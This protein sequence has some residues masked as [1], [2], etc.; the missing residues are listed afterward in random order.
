MRIVIRRGKSPQKLQVEVHC[1][2]PK[3]PKTAVLSSQNNHFD[4]MH[5]SNHAFCACRMRLMRFAPRTT[6]RDRV[7]KGRE[8]VNASPELLGI[9]VLL[10]V[11]T[12][13]GLKAS[14]DSTF[15]TYA[16]KY[17]S[18]LEHPFV[19]MKEFKLFWKIFTLQQN[20]GS[21]WGDLE[22]DRGSTII[23]DEHPELHTCNSGTAPKSSKSGKNNNK[24]KQ[25]Y[26]CPRYSSIFISVKHH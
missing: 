10:G 21:G 20:T 13:G 9:E 16:G 19:S 17:V 11:Y 7:G 12:L 2:G 1:L 25:I 8:E 4:I 15:L 26:I 24:L 14:A 3:S 23:D 22:S 18:C 5:F 6:R